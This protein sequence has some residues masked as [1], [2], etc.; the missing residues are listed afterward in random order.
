M[1]KFGGRTW[2]RLSRKLNIHL[3]TIGW[4]LGAEG[5]HN[6]AKVARWRNVEFKA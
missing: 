3:E 4:E 6:M 2:Q 1:W 5:Y